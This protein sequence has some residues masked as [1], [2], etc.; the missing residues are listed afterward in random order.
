MAGI[1][2]LLSHLHRGSFI[3]STR[4]RLCVI[5]ALIEHTRTGTVLNTHCLWIFCRLLSVRLSVL[6]LIISREFAPLNGSADENILLVMVKSRNSK[7]GIMNI[8]Q[9]SWTRRNEARPSLRQSLRM[10]CRNLSTQTTRALSEY[11]PLGWHFLKYSAVYYIN[12]RA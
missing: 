11:S 4:I 3:F 10:L 2:S 9:G 8:N 6:Y 5:L 12:L 7:G 1:H